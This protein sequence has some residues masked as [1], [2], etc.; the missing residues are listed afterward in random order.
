[1]LENSN[2]CLILAQFKVLNASCSGSRKTLDWRKPVFCFSGSAGAKRLLAL[3][4]DSN[5]RA[6]FFQHLPAGRQGKIQRGGA[7]PDEARPAQG[8]ARES[9]AWVLLFLNVVERVLK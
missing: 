6:L 4:Q 9:P 5:A 1:M 7:Q 2:S 8:E 3:R